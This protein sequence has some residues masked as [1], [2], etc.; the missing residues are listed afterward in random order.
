MARIEGLC[1]P[2]QIMRWLA[3]GRSD[4]GYLPAVGL[5]MES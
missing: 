4:G 5:T 2:A 3:S 1:F